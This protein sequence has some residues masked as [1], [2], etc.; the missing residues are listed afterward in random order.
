MAGRK[1]MLSQT[2]VAQKCSEAAHGHDRPFVV[3]WDATDLASF[4]A[5][6]T[7]DTM[8][9]DYEGCSL[10]VI[11]GC[12]DPNVQ[13][14]LG[15]YG[16]P[17]FTSGTVQGFDVKNEGELYAKL[18]LGA[19]SLS[20]RVA[21]GEE[22]H[23]KYFVSGVATSTRDSVYRGEIKKYPGCAKATHFVW[24]YNLGAFSLGSKE[25]N[26]GEAKVGV[27]AASLGGD[28]SHELSQLAQGGDIASCTTQD[29]R[30][31]RVPIR[32]ALRA[33]T[34]G[35]NPNDRAT[36]AAS[37]DGVPNPT[38]VPGAHFD[39]ASTPAGQA[40]ALIEEA[41]RKKAAGDGTGCLSLFKKAL[42]I[43]ARQGEHLGY[44]IAECTM[45][46]GDCEEGTK[47]IRQVLAARD[48]NH[49][50]LDADL[51]REARDA[52]NREC[53]SSTA[54][55]PTDLVIRTSHELARA[56]AA[57]DGQTCR[58]KFE[59]IDSKIEEADKEAR[60]HR[61]N[62]DPST[63]VWPWNAGTTA[64][65]GGAQC[66]AKATSCDE[67]LKYYKRYYAKVLHGM[68]GTDK[69]ATESWGT[70]IKLG[71]LKCK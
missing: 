67:G 25:N 17:T 69:I 11:Y 31:C 64:L 68:K 24:A 2:A 49:N 21:A 33:I 42:G 39:F 29:Q 28:R 20:A 32:L 9:V 46:S 12:N 5:K 41:Q 16:Q 3:E 30:A 56:E 59:V 34:D 8:F 6:A 1:G 15:T 27:G 14:R 60:E 44:Q 38:P 22:L 37:L 18:P 45:A 26:S 61:Q 66:I 19:A 43:D 4:E 51:D 47:Q 62:R 55:N 50:R 57:G 23:L 70:M 48:T 53:P 65:A 58:A 52:A 7:R 35:D 10:D 71:N 63:A 13:G 40:H 54:K 36:P